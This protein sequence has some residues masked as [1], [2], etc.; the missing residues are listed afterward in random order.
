MGIAGRTPVTYNYEADRLVTRG[1]DVK[2]DPVTGA[3]TRDTIGVVPTTGTYD[4]HGA[5]TGI[6]LRVKGV[7]TWSQRLTRDSIGRRCIERQ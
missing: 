7:I 2:R 1:A 3:I 4:D 6:E 5:L